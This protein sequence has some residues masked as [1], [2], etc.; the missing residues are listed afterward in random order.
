MKKVFDS[1]TLKSQIIKIFIVIILL[2]FVSGCLYGKSGVVKPVTN[3]NHLRE[4]QVAFN[5]S[6]ALENESR[7]GNLNPFEAKDMRAEV[8][9]T[10]AIQ[11]GYASALLSIDKIYPSEEEQLK[12]DKLLGHI[13][14]LKAMAQWRIGD[15]E[16]ALD[17]ADRAIQEAGDQL[18]PRDA[19]VLAALPGLIKI[20]LAF[21][22]I[23][24]M[25]EGGATDENLRILE[26]EIRPRL[27]AKEGGAVNDIKLA[28]SKVN[29]KHEVN[30]YLIQAQLSAYRNYQV[31]HRL[32][33]NTQDPPTGDEVK[34][35]AQYNLQDLKELLDVLKTPVGDTL[36][37][38][39]K[40]LCLIKPEKR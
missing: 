10:I 20:D 19:A 38:Y 4:A 1:I 11:N 5:E 17:T 22:R 12:R 37:L 28:R 36:V 18:Y 14:F 39:W 25:A 7:M 15:F 31:A 13:L 40:E 8:S 35:E 6:A 24:K 21:K 30:L 3:V 27:G 23:E 2:S 29:K 32:A 34:K 9:S 16:N 26:S 33:K